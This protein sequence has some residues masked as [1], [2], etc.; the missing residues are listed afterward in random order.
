MFCCMLAVVCNIPFGELSVVSDTSFVTLDELKLLQ[1]K[2]KFGPFISVNVI[3]DE[4]IDAVNLS[5]SYYYEPKIEFKLFHLI[6]IKTQKLK[7]LQNDK[8]LVS[9]AAI[10]LVLKT[11]GVLVV[12]SSPIST[13]D[14]EY[15]AMVDNNIKL[16]DIILQIQGE[17]VDNVASIKKIINEKDNENKELDVL[18][19]RNNKEV[20]TKL[21]P[22]YDT[23]SESYKIGIWVRDD[24]YGIGTLTYIDANDRFGALGHPICDSDTHSQIDLDSGKVYNCSILGVEKGVT[25]DPGEIHGLFMQGKNEQG[26]VEK[27]NSYGV[28]GTINENSPLKDSA[29]EMNIGGRLS[30]KPGKAQIRCCLDGNKIETFDID[31][32]KTNFQN[33]SNEKS[34]VIRVVDNDLIQRS[35]GIV[36]G[37]S[38]SPI[39]QNDKIVG[40]VTHVFVN[41]PTKGFGVYLDWMIEQ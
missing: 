7:V 1:N 26:I 41:D 16:G 30:V 2:N 12:G 14:G 23:K 10:G 17:N 9:G 20:K 18:I 36:Q 15:D 32:I 3:Q 6:P 28:F 34:M 33:Y 40:A 21:K 37:M 38:G 4:V 31:I 29:Q 11:D 19:K 35:G 22:C 39:I 8:V 24:A 13:V 27:N 25:G 5:N